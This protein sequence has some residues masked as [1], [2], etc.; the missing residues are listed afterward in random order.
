MQIN[1]ET[2]LFKDNKKCRVQTYT[3]RWE[4]E[5]GTEHSDSNVRIVQAG[6]KAEVVSPKSY[7]GKSWWLDCAKYHREAVESLR[8]E[9]WEY[10][11]N[12]PDYKR[13]RLAALYV[14]EEDLILLITGKMKLE[15]NPE[16]EV[17]D[18][19]HDFVTKSLVVTV[20]GSDLAE[21]PEGHEIPRL[22]RPVLSI[23]WED[24]TENITW[25]ENK[26]LL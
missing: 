10:S 17:V 11:S 7:G 6:K 8:K 2:V 4:D 3:E 1:K 18:V 5:Y 22:N 13:R 20:R 26:P 14:A 15:V 9:G 16:Y 25:Y 19:H 21:V 23:R 24:K 12:D